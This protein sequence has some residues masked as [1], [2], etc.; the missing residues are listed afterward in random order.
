MATALLRRLRGALGNALVWAAGWFTA[1]F[2]LFTVLKLVGVA[3]EGATWEGLVRM[4]A[5]VGVMGGLAGTAF[6]TFIGLRYRGRRLSEISWVRFGLGG[7]VVTGLFV[8]SFIIVARLI[9]G[10]PALPLEALVDDERYYTYDKTNGEWEWPFGQP[11]NLILNLAMGGGWGG[12]Q[13][14]DETV[15]SQE[16]LIDYVRVYALK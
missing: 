10:D 13:G 14:M 1:A 16:F 15:E 12:A 2:G 9:A 8:P 3:P 11:Q 5:M 7:A 6:A 4:S